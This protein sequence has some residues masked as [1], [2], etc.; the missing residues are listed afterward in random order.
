MTDTK[1]QGVIAAIPTPVA[2]DGAPDHRRL[3]SFAERLL[4]DGCH[5]LNLLGTTGEATSF[6]VT[7]RRAVMSAFADRGDLLGR[8]MVGTG[9]A[10]GSDAASLLRHADEVGFTGALILPSFY[11]KGLSQAGIADWISFLIDRAGPKRIRIYLYNFPQMTGLTYGKE[12]IDI[13]R[14]RHGGV[15][16][17][18]KDSSGDLAYAED[19][20]Q[21]F[22]G[23]DVFP[24]NEAVL[25]NLRAKGF[26]GCISASVNASAALSRA[27][28]DNP[29]GASAA[30]ITPRM[31]GIR[32][33]LSS[34]PLVPA[35]K[36]AVGILM[37]DAIWARTTPPLTMLDPDQMASLKERLVPLAAA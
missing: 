32:A 8:M 24:S 25:A 2:A 6:D 30:G 16:A 3:V 13:L 14:Q 10:A 21:A 37:D 4:A 35:V 15:I 11:Y 5:G 9:A 36:A 22:P 18:L 1:L 26:A 12:C 33:L 19:L 28:H 23:F 7:T 20:V 29:D 27:V 34:Y 17:G 31:Q